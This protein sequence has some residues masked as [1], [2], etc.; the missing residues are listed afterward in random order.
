MFSVHLDGPRRL[1]LFLVKDFEMSVG[2][3]FSDI[4][5]VQPDYEIRVPQKPTLKV[6]KK[7]AHK[8]IIF[9]RFLHTYAQKPLSWQR[10]IL[11]QCDTYVQRSCRNLH[12][13]RHTGNF[14][15]SRRTRDK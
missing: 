8:N 13:K 3:E 4:N 1:G 9:N 12:N 14:R 2:V 6:Y 15:S 11:N 10:A 5:T 7:V